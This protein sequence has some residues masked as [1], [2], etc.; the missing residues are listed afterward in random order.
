VE[1]L[2]PLQLQA[3][4]IAQHRLRRYCPVVNEADRD[5][6]RQE[7]LIAVWRAATDTCR[8]EHEQRA[9]LV[10]RA[11]GA[12]LDFL[13][14]RYGTRRVHRP[15]FVSDD[16]LVDQRACDEP[17]PLEQLAEQRRL[18]HLLQELERLP[19]RERTVLELL[20][21]RHLN[22]DQSGAVLGVCAARVVQLRHAA[23]ARLR[24]RLVARGW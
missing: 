2:T 22:L 4:K 13:R 16:D 3:V 1:S 9:H 21:D 10:R 7:A 11:L 20:F 14:S 24:R 19:E 15:E 23:A 12:M 5:E 17:G 8:P 18:E 6:L